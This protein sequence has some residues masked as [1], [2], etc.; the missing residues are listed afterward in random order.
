M[1]R[2]VVRKETVLTRVSVT[3]K[4][5]IERAARAAGLSISTYVRLTVLEALK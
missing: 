5:K 4:R 2:Q 3:E 1:A